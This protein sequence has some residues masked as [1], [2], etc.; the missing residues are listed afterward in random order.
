VARRP[1]DPD[2]PV[3]AELLLPLPALVEQRVLVTRSAPAAHHGEATP[4]PVGQ[5]GTRI[6]AER[7]L[8]GC[9]VEVQGAAPYPG[10]ITFLRRSLRS[11]SSA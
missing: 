5:P 7:L 3:T 6:S 8:R 1:A 2:P 11:R 4:E 9:E 10:V